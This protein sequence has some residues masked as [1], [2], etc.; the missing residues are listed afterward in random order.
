MWDSLTQ[1]QREVLVSAAWVLPPAVAVLVLILHRGWARRDA[2]ATAPSRERGGVGRWDWL[3]VVGLTLLMWTCVLGVAVIS[4]MNPDA[5]PPPRPEAGTVAAEAVVTLVIF[6][7][8]PLLV[9]GTRARWLPARLRALGVWPTRPGRDLAAGLLGALLGGVLTLAAIL[10]GTLVV[11][12]LGIDL[13][14]TGHVMLELLLRS[15]D[16]PAMLAALTFSAVVVAP[17]VEETAYRGLMQTS[18]LRLLG[19]HR[20]SA[21]FITSLLFSLAHLTAAGVHTLPGLLVIGLVFGWLYER[22]GSLLTCITAHAA[23]NAG[24]LAATLLLL[25]PAQATP[26]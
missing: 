22:T 11:V 19:G 1:P 8:P 5:P 13:P 2:F 15:R 24:N 3:V 7:L 14:Q 10:P 12:L 17:L 9:L 18:M 23:F 26:G 16:D 6:G 4:W 25:D 20:W 21:I